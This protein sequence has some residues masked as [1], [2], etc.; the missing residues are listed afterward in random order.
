M[1][2][3]HC[4]V[5]ESSVTDFKDYDKFLGDFYCHLK[6]VLK[7][8]IFEY[9]RN[10]NGEIAF[11]SQEGDV[12]NP[13]IQFYN[14]VFKQIFYERNEYPMTTH[15]Y[16]NTMTSRFERINDYLKT[17][18]T[19]P[20]IPAIKQVGIFCNFGPIVELKYKNDELYQKPQQ[21]VLDANKG[22]KSI[23]KE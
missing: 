16:K 14:K 20:G 1:E 23:Q 7:H 4:R 19:P 15:G 9:R 12:N 21:K 17:Q 10:E 5:L 18:L 11:E 8:H 2:D 13:K 3:E 6:V 22:D